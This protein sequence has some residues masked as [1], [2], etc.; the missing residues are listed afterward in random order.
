MR[1]RAVAAVVLISGQSSAQQTCMMQNVVVIVAT[2]PLGEGVDGIPAQI[3]EEV[4][5]HSLLFSVDP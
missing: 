2:E 5:N 1:M 4:A 3:G